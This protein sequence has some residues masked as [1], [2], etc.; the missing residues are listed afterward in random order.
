MPR[1]RRRVP[2]AQL[3]S[4]PAVEEPRVTENRCLNNWRF[5][6]AIA[7]LLGLGSIGGMSWLG[8]GFYRALEA[9]KRSLDNMPLPNSTL[10]PSGK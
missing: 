7:C 1:E 5:V 8:R 6:F 4:M 9:T 3:S 2:G 10:A